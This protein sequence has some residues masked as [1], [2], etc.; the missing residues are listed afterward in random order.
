MFQL[1]SS[2]ISPNYA[3]TLFGIANAIANCSGFI[4]P[5]VT[6]EHTTDGVSLTHC[7]SGEVWSLYS[8]WLATFSHAVFFL[9]NRKIGLKV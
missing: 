2:D 7:F 8:Y 1:N 9:I 6:G 3:G 5:Y 4:A